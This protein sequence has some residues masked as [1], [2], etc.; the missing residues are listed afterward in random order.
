MAKPLQTL[1]SNIGFKFN[2]SYFQ[3]LVTFLSVTMAHNV[4]LSWLNFSKV[5]YM[6]PPSSNFLHSAQTLLSDKY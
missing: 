1:I 6:I 3:F 4:L 2:I 5:V